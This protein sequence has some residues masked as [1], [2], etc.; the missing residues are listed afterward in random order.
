MDTHFIE[1]KDKKGTGEMLKSFVKEKLC[2]LFADKTIL[3]G[4]FKNSSAFTNF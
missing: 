4:C 1:Q 3:C 2:Q